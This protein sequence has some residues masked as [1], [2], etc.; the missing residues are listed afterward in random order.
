MKKVFL[1]VVCQYF[2]QMRRWIHG[3]LVLDIKEKLSRKAKAFLCFIQNS[4]LLLA[5]VHAA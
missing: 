4:S 2:I 3:L 1:L 5:E